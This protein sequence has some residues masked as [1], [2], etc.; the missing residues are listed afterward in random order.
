MRLVAERDAVE[1]APDWVLEFL[2][3]GWAEPDER[4][5]RAA[6]KSTAAL[7][8]PVILEFV[9]QMTKA[10]RDP[11]MVIPQYSF[12]LRPGEESGFD[13][14]NLWTDASYQFANS[15]AN[16]WNAGAPIA[17]C[18]ICGNLIVPEKGRIARTC[19]PQCRLKLH[20]QKKGS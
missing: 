13:Q 5:Q 11:K 18:V 9:A 14:F 7:Y 4:G 15:L 12:S 20:R 17:E 1:N 16:L 8:H 19:S 6:L 10:L 2:A 3:A